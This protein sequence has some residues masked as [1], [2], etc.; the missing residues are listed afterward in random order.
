MLASIQ[1]LRCPRCGATSE[2][3]EKFKKHLDR[4]QPCK[5]T[6]GLDIPL[7]DVRS[8]YDLSEEARDLQES[9]E[10][11]QD[12]VESLWK[13]LEP[14]REE[15]AKLVSSAKNSGNTTINFIMCAQGGTGLSKE[16]I[17]TLTKGI[18]GITEEIRE[19][20]DLSSNVRFNIISLGEPAQTG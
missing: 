10:D 3:R 5:V 15:N 19:E 14:L 2:S 6:T 7:V 9:L 20:M 8:V 13:E 1:S 16:S 17:D 4:K 18:S 11:A 12:E